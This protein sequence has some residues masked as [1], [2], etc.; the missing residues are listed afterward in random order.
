MEWPLTGRDSV[1]PRLAAALS[2]DGVQGI[3][4]VGEAGVGKTR[5]A[6][7]LTESMAA[8]GR[9]FEMITASSASRPLP[10]GVIAHLLPQPDAPAGLGTNPAGLLAWWRGRV[11][12][13]PLTLVVDDAPYLDEPS[14]NFLGLAA[15][16]GAVSLV[17][18]RR[19]ALRLPQLLVELWRGDRFERIEIPPLDEASTT[20]LLT[21]ALGGAV[22]QLSASRLWRRSSGN[23][24]FLRELVRAAAD[25]GS[26]TRGPSG[27]RLTGR[28]APSSRLIELVEARIGRLDARERDAVEAL[29]VG[30]ALGIPI[31]EGIAGSQ[32][33]EHLEERNLLEPLRSGNRQSLRLAH[34]IYGEVVLAATPRTRARRHMRAL[35]DHLERVGA[36]RR[37]DLMRLAVWR[38]EGGG[39]TDP[40]RL[41][42][43]AR[44]ALGAFDATLAE[45]LARAAMSDLGDDVRCRLALGDA[46]AAQERIGE[47]E[48]E[49]ARAAALARSDDEVASV[50]I[51]RANLLF[52]RAGKGADAA[53]L[54]AEASARLTD[55]DWQAEVDSLLTLFRARA[56]DLI[57][58]ARIGGRL[59]SRPN[60]RPR[61]VVHAITYSSIANVMLGRLSEAREQ[62]RIGQL[63]APKAREELPMASA[64]LGFNEALA[65]SYGGNLRAALEQAS[66]GLKTSLAAGIV[67]E[68][69]IWGVIVAECQLLTGDIAAALESAQNSLVLARER[70][71]LSIHGISAGLASVSA[72]WLGN[73]E[74]ARDLRDE[75]ASVAREADV[76]SRMW[77]DR[78]SVWV[79]WLEEGP[80]QAAVRALD[81][82]RRAITHTH[83]VWAAYVFHDAARLGMAKQASIRLRPL[84]GRIEGDLVAT[85]ELATTAMASSDGVSLE[86]AASRFEQMGSL[87]F[88]AESAALAQR[89]Y[90]A[91]GKPRL[92]RIAASRAALLLERC[93]G[94]RTPP[95]FDAARVTLTPRETEIARLVLDG[96]ASRE[97]A[98]RLG[99]S[100][101]TVD[102]HL[103]AVY[104]KLGIQGRSEL[105]A[106]F[107]PASLTDAA[108]GVPEGA[109]KGLS[110]R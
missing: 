98:E 71:P 23:P 51:S 72:A 99:I 31:L 63:L 66:T 65:L 18:T 107:G 20:S 106:V 54:L 87:L 26:L 58:V 44:T 108:A 86:R 34:P 70:D 47:A 57:G 46:L 45:R 14:A 6:A 69:S 39:R 48:A 10:Y 37:D 3:E 22:D 38:L 17:L 95:L 64:M 96:L 105:P 53:R 110:R 92:A 101:R 40:H 61:A 77:L 89:A 76:R 36:R 29:A 5:L 24:L 21:A 12:G 103:G 11:D 85:M 73:L 7:E 93:P 35:A 60:A 1:L 109:S 2:R 16:Q 55:D 13:A 83:L 80:A 74:L 88:A 62:V 68:A 97:V 32:T 15:D 79:T 50:A 27:W 52:F 19:S 84:A 59:A 90:L 67:E 33:V 25:A 78:S 49:Y 41:V 82:G 75:V 104:G 4:I 102:N 94:A 42:A 43:A 9:P 81:A 28:L 30:G 8:S 100:A 56:G 91:R